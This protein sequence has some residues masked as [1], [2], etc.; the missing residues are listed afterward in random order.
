MKRILSLLMSVILMCSLFSISVAAQEVPEQK[1]I[2]AV[3]HLNG[4]TY[5]FDQDE[6]AEFKEQN[7]VTDPFAELSSIPSS[8]EDNS[9]LRSAG[10]WTSISNVVKGTPFL[11]YNK[12]QKVT[13]TIKGPATITSGQSKSFSYTASVSLTATERTIIGGTWSATSNASFSASFPVPANRNGYVQFTPYYRAVT[14]DRIYYVDATIVDTVRIYIT[15]P[16]K[17]GSFADGLYELKLV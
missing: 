15:Q 4:E 1:D 11:N 7:M 14:A 12:N 3:L 17:V 10:S 8:E 9:V 6:L 16:V 13:P 2:V 5:Y